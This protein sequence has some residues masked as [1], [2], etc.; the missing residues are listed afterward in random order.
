MHNGTL[1]WVQLSDARNKSF[2]IYQNIVTYSFFL[3]IVANVLKLEPWFGF[4]NG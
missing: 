2:Y 3:N 1:D 4:N